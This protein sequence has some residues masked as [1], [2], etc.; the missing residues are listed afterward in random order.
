M[1]IVKSQ[2]SIKILW[3]N[4]ETQTNDLLKIVVDL[5]RQIMAVDAEMHADLEE[6]LLENGSDQKDLWGA[7][8][9]GV[10]IYDDF[11]V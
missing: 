2:E 3:E 5:E 8:L 9:E 1:K 7:N 10:S 11:K 4:R 6:L